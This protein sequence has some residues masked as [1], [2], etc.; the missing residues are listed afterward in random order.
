MQPGRTVDTPAIAAAIM[1]PAFA[2][3][4]QRGT[5]RL[6]GHTTS[7]HHEARLRRAVAQYFPNREHVFEFRPFGPAPD[8]WSDATTELVGAIASARAPR[9]RLDGDGLSVRALARQPASVT[10]DVVAIATSLPVTLET[11]I[12]ILDAG[13][14][15]TARSLCE[16]HF[17]AYRNGPINFFESE[18]RMRASAQPELD[19]VVALAGGCRGALISITGHTDASGNEAWNRQLSRA[20]ADAVANWLVERG[21]DAGRIMVQGAGSSEPVASNATRYGR[22]QNRRID[23]G[24]AYP[25]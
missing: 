20:R 24:F 4:A 13:A 16:R 8:W 10:R 1:T 5:V 25:D 23:I 2:I 18:T 17:A 3:S 22:S 11:D 21:V 9:A 12:R 14:E 19:R 6:S 15:V 7:R